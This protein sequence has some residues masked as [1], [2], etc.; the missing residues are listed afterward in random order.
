MY[1]T[2][3]LLSYFNRAC[4]FSVR[5]DWNDDTIILRCDLKVYRYLKTTSWPWSSFW[6]PAKFFLFCLESISQLLSD[7]N[8]FRSYQKRS[9]ELN[10][11][12]KRDKKFKSCMVGHQNV[13]IHL[14]WWWAV[15]LL[16]SGSQSFLGGH[17][18]IDIKVSTGI[19]ITFAKNK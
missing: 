14:W 19:D 6:W 9:F 11:R 12:C 7:T 3:V 2:K 4:T 17:C 1:W 15:V 13:R 5:M 18:P 8:T 16:T 10:W